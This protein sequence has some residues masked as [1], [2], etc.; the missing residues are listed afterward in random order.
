MGKVL[1][2]IRVIEACPGD[3][4]GFGSK[5]LPAEDVCPKGVPNHC[6]LPRLQP[7]SL[8]THLPL[9]LPQGL[10]KH[11]RASL[12]TALAHHPDARW[13]V[14]AAC[15]PEPRYPSTWAW[16]PQLQLRIGRVHVCG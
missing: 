6:K 3:P 9:Q 14:H 15:L 10:C 16:K 7:C 2:V 1:Q 11:E 4:D 13:I 8:R 5:R 12:I